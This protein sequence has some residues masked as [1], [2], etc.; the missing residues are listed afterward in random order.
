MRA[1][2]TVL[3][4]SAHKLWLLPGRV[5]AHK[6]LQS[7]RALTAVLMLLSAHKLWLL[8][9]LQVLGRVIAH[10]ICSPCESAHNCFA[11]ERSQVMVVT[12]ACDSSQI[13]AAHASVHN[14]FAAELSQVLVVTWACDSSQIFAVHASA[15]NCFAAE[16]SQVMVVTWACDS[17]QMFAANESAHNSFVAAERTQMK[18][19][20]C[21]CDSLNICSPCELS[22]LSLTNYL[23][24]NSPGL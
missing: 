20:I 17:S 23:G 5:I 1:L 18:V 3:L 21:A 7:M 10:K 12:W 16:H 8:D 15:H 22:Q 6:Y 11:A 24:E 4:L 14:C 9:L 13:F 2:T 19:V